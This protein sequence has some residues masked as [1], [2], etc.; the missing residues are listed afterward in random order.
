MLAVQSE[1]PDQPEVQAFLLQADERS[2]SLT[3]RR[4]NTV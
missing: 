2:A 4:A 1:K 3:W